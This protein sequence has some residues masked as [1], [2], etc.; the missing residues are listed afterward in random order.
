M[1]DPAFRQFTRRQ[2][3]LA[4]AC[5]AVAPGLAL[6]A[7]GKPVPS[8]GQAL[9]P[10]LPFGMAVTPAQMASSDAALVQ[11][12]ASII[13]AENAMKPS[14]LSPRA[15]GQ[16]SF[17]VADAMVN[18]ALELGLKVRGHTLIWHQQ[19][20]PW[21][22]LENG[23][24]VSRATLIERMRRYITDVVTHFKGRVYAWDVVNEAF[25]FGEANVKTDAEGMRMSPWREI[26]GPEFI[27]IAFEAAS[28]ADPNALLFYNDYETQNADKV[29]A[30]SRMVRQLKGRGIKIDG[31]GHQS[32]MTVTHPR[33][34]EVEAS[35]IAYAELGVT[36][37]ITELDIALNADLT[38]NQV[39]R[40][41]PRLL[42]LQAQRYADMFRLFLKHRD[43]LSAVVVW[44]VDDR[45]SWLNYWPMR[46]FEAPLLLDRQQ[47]PKPA[48]WAVLEVAKAAKTAP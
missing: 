23:Q 16:Y 14:E 8:L 29:K 48:F 15:E 47:Q 39:P 28:A 4:M 5:A 30:V 33:L 42:A 44:G 17:E 37:Q 19:T 27:D 1:T 35:L 22:F 3:T 36:Q 6:G 46:R 13:V 20:P 31:I 32:H 11:H 25:C 34:S 9:G 18:K 40:A 41:T 10:R 26:I 12:H 45:Q 2:L 43:K 24:T 38:K 21:M 7:A